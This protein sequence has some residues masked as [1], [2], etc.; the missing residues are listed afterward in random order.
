MRVLLTD[1]R[2]KGNH[3]G[4]AYTGKQGKN[5]RSDKLSVGATIALEMP[6]V[7]IIRWIYGSACVHKGYMCPHMLRDVC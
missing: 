6:L 7:M 1:H 2:V 5:G 4:I 3:G